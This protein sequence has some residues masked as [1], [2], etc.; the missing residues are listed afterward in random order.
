LVAA[1]TRAWKRSKAWCEKEGL[2]YG[3]A[4]EDAP[5]YTASLDAA[6]TLVPEVYAHGYICD[7]I[8]IEA[9][10]G[11]FTAFGETPAIALC[12]AALKARGVT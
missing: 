10:C 11:V 7:F 4:D 6:M 3:P 1:D 5:E 8:R 2:C 9:K 12:I